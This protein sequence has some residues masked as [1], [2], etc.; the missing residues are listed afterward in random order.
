M[1]DPQKLITAYLDDTLTNAERDE[2]TVWLKAHPDNLRAF[3][4]ANLF[5]QQIRSAITSQ[6]QRDAAGDFVE[7]GKVPLRPETRME[8]VYRWPWFVS[9]GPRLAIAGMAAMVLFTVGVIL[10]LNRSPGASATDLAQITGIWSAQSPDISG[11]F[12]MGQKLGPGRITLVAGAIEITLCNSVSM[13]FEGPGE[14]ELLTPMRAILH[15]GQ[16]VARVPKNARGFRMETPGA[17][18]V[19]LGTEFAV[20]TGSGLSTDVQVYDGQ[21]IATPRSGNATGSFSQRLVAGHAAR[22][23][24]D[25]HTVSQSLAYAPDRF[26]RRL[27]VDPPI[28]LQDMNPKFLNQSRFEEILVTRS[29]QSVVVDGDLSEWNIEGSFRSESEGLTAKDYFIEGRMMYDAKFLYIAAHVGDPAPMLNVIDPGT[30]GE[31]GWRG[32]GLQIRLSTGRTTGW[33]VNANAPCYYQFRGLAPDAS[34]LTRATD[35]QLTHLTFWY[36][37]PSEQSCLHTAYGMDFHGGT[38]NPPGFCGAFRKDVDGRGYTLEYAI[39]WSLLH[40]DTDPPREGD[41]LAISWTAHWSDDSGR[42]WRGQHT[43]I[44]NIS[45]PLRIQPWERAA[46]WGRAV[47]R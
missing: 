41:T 34:N 46:T 9:L 42:L 40:T 23:T 27:P 33:P 29:V 11:L 47:F 5:E 14:L 24:P 13:V 6:A 1:S 25:A 26:V 17:N 35:D 31:L 36:F 10:W 38:V 30:D 43:E 39:P 2:L 7:D 4:E 37:A 20:K 22:Y 19:D 44:R 16:A 18:V 15:A 12:Q 28:E 8:R 21:V 32:G 3:V 45:E